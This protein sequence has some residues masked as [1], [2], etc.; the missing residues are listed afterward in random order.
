MKFGDLS[1]IT[2][3]R[4]SMKTLPAKFALSHFFQSVGEN[5]VRNY[6]YTLCMASSNCFLLLMVVVV[7]SSFII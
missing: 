1:L 7:I 3:L 6:L 4:Y 5:F 2:E